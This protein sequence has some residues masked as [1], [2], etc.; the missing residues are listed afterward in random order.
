MHSY[1]IY[2]V[3]WKNNQKT[4]K[5]SHCHED[6]SMFYFSWSFFN[7]IK[8]LPGNIE[9]DRPSKIGQNLKIFKMLTAERVDREMLIRFH[10]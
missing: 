8:D 7:I 1:V 5:M 9:D 4:I 3:Q 10:F 2:S 6:I